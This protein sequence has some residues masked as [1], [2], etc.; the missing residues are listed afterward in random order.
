MRRAV[1]SIRRRVKSIWW[2][3]RYRTK[4]LRAWINKDA[5]AYLDLHCTDFTIE[6]ADWP[7]CYFVMDGGKEVCC[8]SRAHYTVIAYTF[9]YAGR[10]RGRTAWQA[11]VRAVRHMDRK[12]R[13]SR[14]AD[15]ATHDSVM[16]LMTALGASRGEQK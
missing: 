11:A 1:S 7:R 4:L 2:D 8:G 16:E 13:S 12:V 10:G 5:I 9:W 14:G 15:A 3:V 6:N